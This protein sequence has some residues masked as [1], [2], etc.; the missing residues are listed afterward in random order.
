MCA[1][2]VFY[3]NKF[4]VYKFVLELYLTKQKLAAKKQVVVAMSFLFS[5]FEKCIYYVK[6]TEYIIM[7]NKSTLRVL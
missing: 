2:T 5:A 3:V 4:R 7:S 1:N 6:Q